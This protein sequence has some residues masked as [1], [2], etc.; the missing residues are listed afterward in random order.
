MFSGAT[1]GTAVE[2][3][4]QA[5]GCILYVGRSSAVILTYV[6]LSAASIVYIIRCVHSRYI[7]A[8]PSRKNTTNTNRV[9]SP[10]V[11]ST[12]PTAQIQHE[13]PRVSPAT[14]LLLEQY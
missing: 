5:R 3:R 8:S 1:G 13:R 2:G 7:K 6:A 10:T 14:N 9:S 11:S 12:S 4:R